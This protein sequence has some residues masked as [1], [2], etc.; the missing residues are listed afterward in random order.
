ME[1]HD[2]AYYEAHAQDVNLEDITSDEHNAYLLARLRDNNPYVDFPWFSIVTEREDDEEG[3]EFL[4]REGDDL[5]WLGYF[6]GRSET[7]SILYINNFPD[8]INLD[9]FF[10]GLGHNRSIESLQIWGDLGESFQGLIPFLRNNDILEELH[11]NAFGIGLHCARNIALLLSQQSSLKRIVFDDTVFDHE[12]FSQI[13]AALRSQPQM[14]ELCIY[15]GNNSVGRNGCVALGNVLEGCLSLKKLNLSAFGNNGAIE[16]L[17][18]DVGLRALV[19]GLKHC[20]NLTS[21]ELYGNLMITEEGSRSLSTLFQSDGCRLECL[22]LG[23]MS[24]DDDGAAMLAT[25]LASLPSLKRLNLK[26]ISISDECFQHVVR[27]L[28][29]C[30]IEVLDLFGSLLMDSVLG[31]RTLGTVVQRTRSMHRLSLRGCSL[32]D[33]GLQSFVDGVANF[34][35]LRELD[36]SHNRSITANGLA[37]LSL[38]LQAEHCAL[39]TLCLYGIHLGDDEVA[40]LA[41]GLIR[42]KSLIELTCFRRDSGITARGWA[43]FSKLLCDTSSVNNT[44]LSNHTLL[45]TGLHDT[46]Q[47]ITECL[48]LNR[49]HAPAICKILHCHPDI[50]ITPLLQF[51]LLCLPLVLE[52]FEKARLHLDEVNES[53]EAFHC[54]ELSAVY[55]FVR[56]MPLLA[57]DGYSQK[58]DIQLQSISRK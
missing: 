49:N 45:A 46:P 47:H 38:L 39:R 8:N 14:E 48:R 34:C 23:R 16:G 41:N 3:Y 21:L 36:L 4:I 5:G 33:E 18:D 50:D 57:V 20:R 17:I 31:L 9:A 43:A 10:V 51:D 42:N 12:G 22:D 2:Y 25:G 32:T 13:T 52:W 26:G 27:G 55:N 30:N 53:S 58:K 40:A 6:V 7:F 15:G 28:V 29:D 37:S 19:E 44:Y 24:I 35:S 54:R 11:F 1:V 56:G